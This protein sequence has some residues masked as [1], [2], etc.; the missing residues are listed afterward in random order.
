VASLQQAWDAVQK[1]ETLGQRAA[2]APELLRAIDFFG[3]K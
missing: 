2:H 1:G 3:K